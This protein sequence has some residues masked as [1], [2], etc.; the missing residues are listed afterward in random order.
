MLVISFELAPV[1]LRRTAFTARNRSFPCEKS[2]GFALKLVVQST[3]TAPSFT[4][5]P[6]FRSASIL[7]FISFSCSSALFSFRD[8]GIYDIFVAFGIEFWVYGKE[9]VFT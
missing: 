6:R 3:A 8:G 2:N 1:L 7:V 9:V 4:F 5:S